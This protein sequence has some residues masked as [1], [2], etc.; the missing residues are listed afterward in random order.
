[1]TCG[2]NSPPGSGKISSERLFRLIRPRSIAVIG[3]REAE[4]VAEQCDRM[5]FEGDVWPVHPSRGSVAGR[6]AFRS[7]AEL[8][9]AP[10]A[11]FIGVNR[12]ATIETV[13]A[14][15][16]VGAGGAVCYASGF[17]ESNDGETLQRALVEAAA[18]MP[19]VGP[20]CYGLINFLD[21]V[22]LWPDQHGGR[23][24]D[25]AERG[26]AIVCQSSNI[27]VSLTMQRRGLPVA[28]LVTVGNQ[29][30]LGISHLASILLDDER[31]SAIGLHVEGFDSVAGFE[32]LALKAR[33]RSVPV[34]VLKTGRSE[35]ARAANLTHTASIA[36]HEAGANAFLR[37]LGF[38]RVHGIPELLESLKLLHVHGGLAGVRLGAMCCSG[39]ETSLLSDT[40]Q[41]TGL[42]FPDLVPEHAASVRATVHPLVSVD[43]PFD[44][45][46]FS[47]GNE[48]ELTETFTTFALGDFDATMLVLDFPRID[49]CDDTDWEPAVEAFCRAMAVSGAK[50]V[51]AATLAE[52][53]PEER[54]ARLIERGI[55]PLAGVR[56]AFSAIECAA[57]IGEAWQSAPGAPVLDGGCLPTRPLLLDEA[58]AKVR[59]AEYAVGIPQGSVART[60][61][62]AVAAAAALGGPVAVKA[63]GIAHKTEVDAV[64][65]G[66]REPDEIRNA[67]RDLLAHGDGV[68][69]ERFEDGIVAELIVGLHR[70]SRFGLLLIVG[71]GGVFVELAADSETLLLP[72]TESEIRGALSRL[73]CA[74]LLGGWR[75]REPA[76]IDA[77]VAA[78]LGIVAFAVANCDR[79]EELDVNPLGIRTRGQGAVALDALI[80]TR[81][82]RA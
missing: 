23:R 66:L 58:S 60:E 35:K 12:H 7:V 44:Y 62:E 61:E 74:R 38:A 73:R 56:E 37:R 59:I 15:S 21:G 79:I 34:V 54:A 45:H 1:M 8:P 67:A 16:R 70:D 18:E 75:G 20:N 42:T 77:A 14:L 78:I 82:S 11:A 64:R 76:D 36:G 19:I 68:L 50:G 6:A 47:W 28:Y 33:D 22:P 65:L 51:I 49:R 3:G 72:A 24:L 69:V 46:T 29:A 5:G 71:S 57:R 52:D 43:N 55:A 53:L 80:R 81:E 4:R 26:V 32:A 30:Q 9:V 63:L 13:A 2:S 17:L 27:A 31:V 40:I 10:D 41:E 39:G 48:A 25:P